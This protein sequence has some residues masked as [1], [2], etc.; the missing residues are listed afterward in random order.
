MQ[1]YY[2]MFPGIYLERPLVLTGFLGSQTAQTAQAVC[3]LTGLPLVDLDR[4]IESRAGRSISHFL[5][6]EGECAF[7]N[8]EHALLVQALDRTPPPVIALGDG[9]LLSA[10][11]RSL[12]LDR[13]DLVW[14]TAPLSELA[15]R[16]RVQLEKRPGSV[17]AFMQKGSVV[18]AL[19]LQP[20]YEDRV[21][22]Y[23]TAAESV[24]IRGKTPTQVAQ[25]LIA[26][27]GLGA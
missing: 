8:V 6:R 14:L 22:G 19:G 15:S 24:D 27:R 2:D 26:L 23:A 11:N 7:R 21:E 12:V 20:L 5:L 4:D 16:V 17:P 9:A 25:H 10:E 18:T 3:A 13:A 1:G